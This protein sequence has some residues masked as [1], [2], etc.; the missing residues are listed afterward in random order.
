[1]QK[2]FNFLKSNWLKIVGGLIVVGIIGGVF[3]G[4][5]VLGNK[6]ANGGILRIT[7]L[8]N[9]EVGMASSTDFALFWQVW[10]TLNDKYVATH[11]TSTIVTSQDRVYG[12]IKGMVAALGDPYTVFFPP[13]DAAL[14]KSE[15]SGNFQGIGLEIGVKQGNIVA[16]SPLKGSPAEKAGI[17]PKD[18]IVKIDGVSTDG[19]STDEAVKLIRGAKGTSVTLTLFRDSKK[20]PF[21]VKVVRDTINVPT[22]DTKARNDGVFVISLYSFSEN[23]PDLFRSALK[24]FVQSGDSKLVLDLRGN[25]GGY[26][27]AAVDMASWF[28]PA[29][30]V[31]VSEDYG[32][33]KAPDV[34]KSK[35]YNIFNNN[36]KMVILVDQGT[37]SAA[38]ILSGALS[39]QGIAKLVGQKT[40]GK[41]SV[42]ELL[43]LP[44]DASLKVTVA[45]WLTPKGKSISQEG[46][47]PDVVASTTPDDMATGKDPQMDAAIK[48]L[49]N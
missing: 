13:S 43:P 8:S 25:P 28:L 18:I 42:Q 32:G 45:R 44:N 36:L 16:V 20:E 41:G 24:Q 10:N 30:K 1:M 3:W 12:A 11:G 37:A 9:K 15:I 38:E 27:E 29:D 6:S 40:F 21:D 4:G 19:I 7:E 17:L 14:F 23:S 47:V 46:I 2:I 22:L 5:Y 48:L 49:T 35:G 39:E 33:G 26:L 31:I 34:Y